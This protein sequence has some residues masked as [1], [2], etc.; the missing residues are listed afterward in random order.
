MKRKFFQDLIVVSVLV[1]IVVLAFPVVSRTLQAYEVSAKPTCGKNQMVW[2]RQ[3]VT[4]KCNCLPDT[5]VAKGYTKDPSCG[6]PDPSATVLVTYMPPTVTSLPN[7]PTA[8][9]SGPN[10]V[11][12]TPVCTATAK[13]DP[14]I[15]IGTVD[16]KFT[17][18]ATPV[19]DLC[20]QARRSADAQGTQAAAQSTR[21]AVE[22][23][24]IIIELTRKP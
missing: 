2:Y 13:L 22:A 4:G 7:T 11:T 23:T 19:C 20:D 6:E 17:V 18:T 3:N 9:R 8:T 12:A 1:G 15:P 14:A 5:A 10:V 16:P 21:A 24:R